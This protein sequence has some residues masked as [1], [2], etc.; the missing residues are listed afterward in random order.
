MRRQTADHDC[1]PTAIAN[2]LEVHHRRV[3]LR[4]LRE[5]VGTTDDGSDEH[6]L[7]RALLA[8]GAGVDEHRGRCAF[9]ARE[10]LAESTAAGR[11]V[12]LCVDRWQH[13]VTLIG[14]V[15]AQLVIYDPARETGG[16]SVL[17]WKQLAQ[18]WEAAR[19]AARA[20][21]SPGVRFYGIAVG[22]PSIK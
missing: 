11:P 13:W 20:A 16:V 5:L 2:A 9:A 14:A 12:L 17:R 7:I 22:P 21:G 18:R 6:D 19:R 3:G 4:G 8:Y 15:G 10:W 1:G